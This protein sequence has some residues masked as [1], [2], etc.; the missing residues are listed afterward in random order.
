MKSSGSSADASRPLT[1]DRTCA[2][3]DCGPGDWTVF[4][5][6]SKVCRGFDGY[7]Y[8]VSPQLLARV[9]QRWSAA[10]LDLDAAWRASVAGLP[11]FAALDAL[12]RFPDSRPID[13]SCCGQ[14]A[15]LLRHLHGPT[16][17]VTSRSVTLAEARPWSLCPLNSWQRRGLRC[18]WL[19][20]LAAAWPSAAQL[21]GGRRRRQAACA[22]PAARGRGL[23]R[24]QGR[25]PFGRRPSRPPG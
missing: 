4:E 5:R 19:E 1:P 7:Y 3:N 10:G 24:A 9:R 8:G 22:S 13:L 20:P 12:P 11:G 16:T 2:A 21:C 18:R 25:R 23:R 15:L 6:V 14:T 17:A